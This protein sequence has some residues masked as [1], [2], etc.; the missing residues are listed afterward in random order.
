MCHADDEDIRKLLC[1]K[2]VLMAVRKTAVE[3][4]RAD[5]LF[6]GLCVRIEAIL[7]GI[8][9]LYPELKQTIESIREEVFDLG[10][11]TPFWEARL[12]RME[13][14]GVVL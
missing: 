3:Y 5:Q 14:M 2:Y 12:D 1:L 6:R 11:L 9:D 10:I 13:E 8:E 4:E 7:K